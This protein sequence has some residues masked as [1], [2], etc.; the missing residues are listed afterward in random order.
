MTKVTDLMSSRARFYLHDPVS[1]LH[2]RVVGRPMRGGGGGSET[3]AVS[4][5]S[6]M[7]GATHVAG[8]P[9]VIS[10]FHQGKLSLPSK[11]L[12]GR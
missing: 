8:D 1:R 2:A 4:L 5:S 3:Q 6:A 10:V 7:V 12:T 9:E 11:M